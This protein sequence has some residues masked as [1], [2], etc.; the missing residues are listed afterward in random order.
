MPEPFDEESAQALAAKLD[1]FDL[2]A[3]ERAI[4]QAIFTIAAGDDVDG[5]ATPTPGGPV[6]IPYPNVAMANG[7]R[8]APL[9]TSFLAAF[10]SRNGFLGPT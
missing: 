1:G 4:L 6:P 7:A 2:S 8:S 5:F 9:S 10:R 3:D